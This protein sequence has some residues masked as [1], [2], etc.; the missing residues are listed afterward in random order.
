VTFLRSWLDR[1][2]RA[3][4]PAPAPDHPLTAEERA[5]RPETRVDDA[6]R[7]VADQ[8]GAEEER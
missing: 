8:L 3:W 2:R 5:D 7:I 4:I 6:A 1:I